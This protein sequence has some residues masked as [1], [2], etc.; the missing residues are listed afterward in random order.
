MASRV[1]R[2]GRNRQRALSAILDAEEPFSVEDVWNAVGR[3]F[4]PSYQIVADTILRLR[5]GGVIERVF[6]EGYP[7]GPKK[8]Y[9]WVRRVP[10]RD[11]DAVLLGRGDRP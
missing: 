3:G 4:D 5:E 1:E 10:S 7:T 9:R 2:A 8:F 6:P 11:A